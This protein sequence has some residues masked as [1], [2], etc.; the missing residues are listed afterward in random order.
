MVVE[1][2]ENNFI[3]HSCYCAGSCSYYPI[4]DALHTLPINEVV[5]NGRK[6]RA[7]VDTGCTATLLIPEIAEDWNG[8]SRI[9]VVDGRDLD[10]KGIS[11]VKLVVS[12]MKLN[13]NAVVRD[14]MVEGIDLVMGMDAIHQLGG[15]LINGDELDF[16]TAKCRR[17]VEKKRKWS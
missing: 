6:L 8:K 7:L 12:G 10:C 3:W 2:R 17:R 15:V 16:R 14:R 13:I 9:T 11:L 5:I 4:N 1:R